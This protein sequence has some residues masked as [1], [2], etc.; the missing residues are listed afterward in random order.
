MTKLSVCILGGTGF[1][2]R[3]LAHRLV[4]IGH[5]VRV[6]TRRRERQ[7]RGLLVLPTLY[8]AEGDVH[9]PAVLR[10]QFKG[11]D[12]V[13]NLVG[14]LNEKGYRGK[15][16]EKVHV[17]LPRKVVNACREVEVPRLLH[18]S[19][20]RAS[21]DGPSYYLRT[22]ARGE[23]VVHSAE[24]TNFNV[25]SF[26]PSVIFGPRDSFINRFATLLRL[27]PLV[28]P[29]ACPT[30]RFQPVFVD[31]VVSA[32]VHALHDHDTF[33]QRY[34]LCGPNV[35]T[36]KTLVAYTAGL[37]GL[38]R[39]II[40]LN[41]TMSKMQATC[42]QFVPGKPFSLDNY[43]SLQVA[44]ICDKG[45]PPIFG[46]EPTTLESVVPTYLVGRRPRSAKYS[47]F[48]QLAGRE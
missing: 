28:F 34:D 46:I 27:S 15:G 26:R 29:L 16:F 1:V 44:S 25:T 10:Q 30:S 2:G 24:K 5:D 18:M 22:K 32:F 14:I 47:D 42:M 23:E 45:F 36:L 8:L 17:D 40:E 6:I 35:Y 31:D 3:E 13:I 20:L 11:M 19:A 41:D 9:N 43:R 39:R 33:G 21:M 37:L 7:K 48:R 38:R 12:A 4:A